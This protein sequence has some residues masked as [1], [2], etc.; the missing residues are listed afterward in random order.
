V[1]AQT[2][3]T[4]EDSWDGSAADTSRSAANTASAAESM[5]YGRLY[6]GDALFERLAQ[7]LQDVASQLGPCIQEAHAV[8]GQRHLA[9]HRPVAA[10][11]QPHIG[12]GVVGARKGGWRSTPCGR[13]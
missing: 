2:L 13:R 7:D 1:A 10:A 11:D 12:E 4:R 6:F 3:A 5:T 8:V 9:R